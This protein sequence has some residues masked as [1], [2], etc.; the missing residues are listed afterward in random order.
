MNL[1][2]RLAISSLR[3]SSLKLF[4]KQS[5]KKPCFFWF[6]YEVLGIS[7]RSTSTLSSIENITVKSMEFAVKFR[8]AS[9]FTFFLALQLF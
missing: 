6:F 5:A 2:C 9:A 1:E 4:T 7:R 3:F 8:S